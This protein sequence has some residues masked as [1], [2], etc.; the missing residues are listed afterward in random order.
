MQIEIKTDRSKKIKKIS[1][2]VFGII[3]PTKRILEK[4]KRKEKYQKTNQD[5]YCD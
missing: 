1:R 2:A 4:T 3:K 5:R